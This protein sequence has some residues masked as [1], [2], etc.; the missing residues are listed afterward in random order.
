MFPQITET[1][2]YLSYGLLSNVALSLYYKAPREAL[3]DEF[4][5]LHRWAMKRAH[6]ARLRR[7]VMDSESP[8][9]FCDCGN[10]ASTSI[11]QNLFCSRCANIY[12]QETQH[13]N[14]Q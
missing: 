11:E 7:E 1:I 2:K 4:F 13:A 6:I 12:Y 5:L 10:P 9:L 14:E 3:Q 8:T